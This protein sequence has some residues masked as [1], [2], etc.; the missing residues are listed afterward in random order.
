MLPCWHGVRKTALQTSTLSNDVNSTV[1]ASKTTDTPTKVIEERQIFRSGDGLSAFS[2]SR[3]KIYGVLRKIFRLTCGRSAL[4]W[5][6]A[7]QWWAPHHRSGG[8]RLPAV[9]PSTAIP[10][11]LLAVPRQCASR[12]LCSHRSLEHEKTGHHLPGLAN[13]LL[14]FMV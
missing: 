11:D 3:K 8:P 2:T 5:A 4:R 12:P 14:R 7:S 10:L 9:R 13:V 1:A 6:H